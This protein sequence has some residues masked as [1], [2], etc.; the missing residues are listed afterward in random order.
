MFTI[1]DKGT[2]QN[3][4]QSI[5]FKE[6]IE[7]LAA[8]IGKK[9]CVLSGL[10]VTAQGTPDMTVAVA[11]GA[12]LS[13]ETMFAVAAANATIGTANASNPRL[14][15]VVITSAGAIA[16]RA[17]TAAAS[18]KPPARTANDVVIAVV[19][20]P[21]NDTTIGSDQIT[22]LRVMAGLP[23]VLKKVTSAAATNTTNAAFAAF[24]AT[25]PNGLFLSGRTL[26]LKL[27]GNYLFNSG[28]PTWKLQ[29]KY[30]GTTM[31][32]DL[33]GSAT[34]D[35]DRGAW[36]LDLC[37]TAQAN[38]DQSVNGVFNYQQMGAKSAPTTGIG[39]MTS[40]LQMTTL[41]FSGSA[42]VDSDAGDRVFEVDMTMSVSNANDE[43]LVEGAILELL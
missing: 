43:I 8:G 2:G 10:A 36:T 23:V 14:D 20:V 42:A 35:T 28:S 37:L 33:T 16:V 17:G 38:N 18:P 40:A 7:V 30:G 15:L 24:T 19:Y 25:I 6:Y 11:K 9:D 13:N 32:D 26:R 12:V 3:D 41:P 34:A 22:D 27:F 39:D 21:A 29:V 1:P 5:L 31:F 4:L